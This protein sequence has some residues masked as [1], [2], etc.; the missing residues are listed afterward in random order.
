M[1]LAGTA[2]AALAGV[3]IWRFRPTG[4]PKLAVL[5]FRNI[6][7][8][9]EAERIGQRITENLIETLQDTPWLDVTPLDAVSSF[10]DQDVFP[11]EAGSKLGA[12]FILTGDVRLENG[13]PVINAEL[14]SAATRK[15]LWNET[16]NSF[17]YNTHEQIASAII[18]QEDLRILT[19]FER[20][21]RKALPSVNEEAWTSYWRG[22]RQFGLGGPTGYEKALDFFQGAFQLDSHFALACSSAAAVWAAKAIDGIESP[23]EC[24][25]NHEHYLQIAN[26]LDSN[27]PGVHSERAMRAFL[28]DWNWSTAEK[29]FELSITP[30]RGYVV[31]PSYYGLYAL[32][33][34]AVRHLHKAFALAATARKT[35]KKLGDGHSGLEA[36]LMLSEGH[37]DDAINRYRDVLRLYPGKVNAQLGLAEAYRMKGDFSKAIAILRPIA[38]RNGLIDESLGQLSTDSGK[39]GYRKIVHAM[40]R[41]DLQVLDIK[42][43]EAEYVSPLDRARDYVQ[44]DDRDA[45]FRNLE[46][47]FEEKASGLVFLKVDPVWNAVRDDER[48]RGFVGRMKFP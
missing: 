48:F 9:T 3:T 45:A 37:I 27:L 26:E 42:D 40:A 2:V 39:D 1:W 13:D 30:R 5:P 28:W 46:D 22:Y 25:K 17:S 31:D 20:E 35:R 15:Q 34:W 19:D 16:Y 38:A 44:L 6:K 43:A 23:N 7:K 33:C 29:E 11:R 24:F 47:A 10:K 14:Y 4:L 12:S 18:D 8:N 32:E 21:Q 41:A 36:N